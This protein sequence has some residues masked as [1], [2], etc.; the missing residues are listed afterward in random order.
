MNQFLKTKFSKTLFSNIIFFPKIFKKISKF[1][2]SKIFF[3]KRFSKKVLNKKIQKKL[4]KSLFLERIFQFLSCMKTSRIFLLMYTDESLVYTE[5]AKPF[6]RSPALV[7][8]KKCI[9]RFLAGV[10]GLVSCFVRLCVR[11]C[12]RPEPK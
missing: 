11:S 12:V 2:F 7:L 9:V 8:M 3:R 1:F 5:A 6:S 10:P 4:E